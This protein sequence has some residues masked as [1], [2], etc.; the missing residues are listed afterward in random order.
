MR[1]ATPSRRPGSR[2]AAL[3]INHP[4]RTLALL[5][6]LFVV[7]GVVGGPV[8]GLLSG[9][10][11]D[12][13]NSESAR[14]SQRLQDA[15]G[16]PA[17][18]SMVVLIRA[19][20][21]V[22]G[23]SGQAY[24]QSVAARLRSED[25]VANV[26][27]PY[28]PRNPAL[29]SGDGRSAYLVANIRAA[30]ATKAEDV[31]KP[32][33]ARLAQDSRITVGGGLIAG[34]EVGDQVS[35]DIGRAELVAFPILFIVLVFVLRGVVV[36]L[37]PIALGMLSILTTFTALRIVNGFT[38]ISIFAVNLVTGLGL[39][40]ALDYGL[41]FITRYREEAAATGYGREALVR[42]LGTS[43]RTVLF[44][45]LTVAAA[46]ASLILFP[47]RFLYSM[48]IGGVL[49]APIAVAIALTFLPAVLL[50]LGRRVE[51]WS[52]FHLDREREHQARGAWY[53]LSRF[54]M[55]RPVVVA[56]ATGTLLIVMGTPFLRITFTSVDASVLPHNTSAR[57]VDDALR[58]EFPTDTSNPL[59]AV[60]RAPDVSAARSS[61][62]AYVQRLRGLPNVRAVTPPRYAGNDTWAVDVISTQPPLSQASQGLVT[63]VRN[64]SSPYSVLVTGY[65][66]YFKD[67]QSS[68]RSHLPG[69]ILWVCLTTIVILFVMT[70][71][72]LL[73]FKS[74]LMNALSLS[75]AFG[76]LILIFQDGRFTG[77]LQYESQG[78]LESTQPILLFAIAFGLSTD[79]GVFLLGR[80]KEE[81][82]AGLSTPEAVALGMQRTGRVITAAAFLFCIAIGAFAS[83]SIVFI[84][85]VGVGT[86]L[87]VLIDATIVR[88]LLVPALMAL[89]GRWNWWAPRPL[90]R[91]HRRLGLERLEAGAGTRAG[92][93]A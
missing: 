48:G 59:T 34:K 62:D 73:P 47:L 8:A 58:H 30:D 5:A 78:A 18:S 82:D 17:D 71:S 68:L 92:A 63:A 55:R 29:I 19:G 51:T 35:G 31:A 50:V 69:A 36:A 88:A 11:F 86:A 20:T 21:D 70:G 44:S 52:W 80:I 60:I 53:Q 9:G 38:P 45:S 12:D 72:L 1:S 79:Y 74:V 91:L 14:A 75:A 57:Q 32:I 54:V 33:A 90:R 25:H 56:L 23:G 15:T 64:V 85:E 42:T 87:A 2:L 7:G 89:L 27:D 43:G 41:L 67:L 37:L 77:L 40:L 6:M 49:A 10:G 84:K 22:R 16:V 93:T 24:V 13:P 81:H 65:A 46:M 26:V 4:R 76:L 39:G 28:S 83:S 3:S 66:A 61:L